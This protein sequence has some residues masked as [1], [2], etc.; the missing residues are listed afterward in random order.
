MGD[1][2][3]FGS[4]NVGGDVRRIP[5]VATAAGD[6]QIRSIRPAEVVQSG[7]HAQCSVFGRAA[8]ITRGSFRVLRELSAALPVRA[9]VED[10]T[11][12]PAAT[13]PAIVPRDQTHPIRFCYL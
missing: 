13:P 12:F 5:R 11:G 6:R 8:W 4:G 10:A 7:R 9:S 2:R 1:S 3:N